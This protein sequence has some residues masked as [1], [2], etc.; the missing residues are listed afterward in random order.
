MPAFLQQS[1]EHQSD[2]EIARFHLPNADGQ[3]LEIHEDRDEWL[4][5]HR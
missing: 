1:F 3:V 5:R 2:L 4:C